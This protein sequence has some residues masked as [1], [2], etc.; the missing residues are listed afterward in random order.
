MTEHDIQVAYFDW[1]RVTAPDV[2]EYTFAIPN[3]GLR[4]IVTAANLKKEGVKAGVPDIMIAVA[5]K[6]FCGMFIET[7]KPTGRLTTKQKSWIDRLKRGGYKV[8]VCYGLQ[9]MMEATEDYFTET[10]VYY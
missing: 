1:L 4:N 5:Q 2:W 9:D 3:G 6:G 10:R 7:K 8:E